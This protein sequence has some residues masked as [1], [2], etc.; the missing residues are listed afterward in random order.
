VAIVSESSRGL[1]NEINVTPLVDVVLVL[2]IIFMVVTP[3]LQRGKEVD[4]PA[5]RGDDPEAQRKRAALVV[6][7][8]RDRRVW[9][10]N[11]EYGVD[12]VSRAVSRELAF[13][14]QRRVLLKGDRSLNVGDVRAVMRAIRAGGARDVM[15][16]VKDKPVPR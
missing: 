15:L 6:S 14:G 7:V 4:L 10:G 16:A 1:R 11:D 8:T 3:V 12:E 5:A 13:S 2:L 9:M